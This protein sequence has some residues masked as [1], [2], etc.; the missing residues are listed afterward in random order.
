MS[1][2]EYKEK[3]QRNKSGEEMPSLGWAKSIA[4]TKEAERMWAWLLHVTANWLRAVSDIEITTPNLE[5]RCGT[6]LDLLCFH[7]LTQQLSI[8]FC[9]QK[10]TEI[11]GT[12]G[13]GSEKQSGFSMRSPGLRGLLTMGFGDRDP[14]LEKPK[15]Q[16]RT[17]VVVFG[18]VFFFFFCFF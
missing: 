8:V 6:G 16:Q 7:C 15:N 3:R 5:D 9:S 18:F 2:E 13:G 11:K 14:E 4:Q 12:G 10:L 17:W 1:E